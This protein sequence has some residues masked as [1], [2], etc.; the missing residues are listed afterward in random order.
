ML[1]LRLGVA[2]RR[3]VSAVSPDCDTT[4]ISPS[5]GSGASR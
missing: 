1:A 2:Q 3:Q 4:I 5:S